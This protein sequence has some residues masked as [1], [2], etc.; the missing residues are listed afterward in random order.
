MQPHHEDSQKKLLDD[1]MTLLEY[2]LALDKHNWE[3]RFSPDAN[4]VCQGFYEKMFLRNVSRISE[5]H[6]NLFDQF[7]R[8]KLLGGDKPR[9][10]E[11][12]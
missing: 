3:Y 8:F 4:V 2:Y 6:N 11:I 1:Q 12:T 5:A 9:L 7:Y 10:P